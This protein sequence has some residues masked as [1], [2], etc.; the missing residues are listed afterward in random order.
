MAKHTMQELKMRQKLPLEVKILMTKQR[1]N[2]LVSSF[3][4]DTIKRSWGRNRGACRNTT[5]AGN[6]AWKLEITPLQSGRWDDV[7]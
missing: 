1:I 3:R 5:R 2:L 6:L 7:R 4:D